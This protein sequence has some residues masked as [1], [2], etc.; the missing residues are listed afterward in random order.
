MVDIASGLSQVYNFWQLAL[1]TNWFGLQCP[2]HCGHPSTSALICS[3][4]ITSSNPVP[5]LVC[6]LATVI[7]A[8]A[9]RMPRVI[10]QNA[11]GK[12]KRG[13]VKVAEYDPDV[14][15]NKLEAYVKSVGVNKAFDLHSYKSLPVS[16]AARGNDLVKMHKWVMAILSVNP[17]GRLLVSFLF[18]GFHFFV[19]F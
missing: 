11:N 6:F 4:L 5:A 14:L 1:A 3:F 13:R 17:Q 2:L 15:K 10:Q 12:A 7:T 18:F 9:A 19:V 8:M 16:N